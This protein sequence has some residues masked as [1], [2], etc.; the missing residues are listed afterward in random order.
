MYE[1]EILLGHFNVPDCFDI[2]IRLTCDDNH[3]V[4][5]VVID[6]A[7]EFGSSIDQSY[8]KYGSKIGTI[9]ECILT[10]IEN[11]LEER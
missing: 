5:C 8:S 6:N 9:M 2:T 3:T 11:V 7:N 4:K 10:N 1:D